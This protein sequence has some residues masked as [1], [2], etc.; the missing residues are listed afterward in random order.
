MTFLFLREDTSP[1]LVFAGK[2]N[3]LPW[4]VGYVNALQQTS[5]FVRVN[6]RGILFAGGSRDRDNLRNLDEDSVWRSFE[7]VRS[8]NALCTGKH[9]EVFPNYRAD[10]PFTYETFAESAYT[11][12]KCSGS[13]WAGGHLT[14]AGRVVNGSDDTYEITVCDLFEGLDIVFKQN[15]DKIYW[16]PQPD[17]TTENIF[18]AIVAILIA[19]CLCA[20]ITAVLENKK[21]SAIWSHLVILVVSIALVSLNGFQPSEF[22]T[23][24]DLRIWLVLVVF[25]WF[26][27]VVQISRD[28]GQVLIQDNN[29]F[30]VIKVILTLDSEHLPIREA[31]DTGLTIFTATLMLLATASHNSFDNPYLAP[32]VTLFGIRTWWKYLQFQTHLLRGIWQSRRQLVNFIWNLFIVLVDCFVYVLVLGAATPGLGFSVLTCVFISFVTAFFVIFKMDFAV[33]DSSERRQ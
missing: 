17:S 32:L 24:N 20:N 25:V 14:G 11:G 15:S 12:T 19:A 27:C 6:A 31:A 8:E 5:R 13:A 1:L 18:M 22:V 28:V 9:V 21:I 16:R 29:I 7:C 23:V 33:N 26:E 10:V 4:H 3:A 30:K 2:Q